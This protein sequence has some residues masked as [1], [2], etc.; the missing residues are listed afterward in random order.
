M[1]TGSILSHIGSEDE[2]SRGSSAKRFR[3]TGG[4]SAPGGSS[5]ASNAIKDDPALGNQ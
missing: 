5:S 1:K 2:M 3:L 4:G